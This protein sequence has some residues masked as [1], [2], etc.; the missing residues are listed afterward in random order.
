MSLFNQLI[1]S[2]DEAEAHLTGKK[3]LKT[4]SLSIKKLPSYT[5][6]EIKAIRKHAYLTQSSLADLLGVSKKT[7]EAWES[8]KNK[9]NGSSLRLLQLLSQD[10]DSIVKEI[11][12]TR[13]TVSQ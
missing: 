7:I 11:S 12:E 5:S 2:I 8:G 6:I 9:P 10:S 13:E 3:R 4:K 1:D